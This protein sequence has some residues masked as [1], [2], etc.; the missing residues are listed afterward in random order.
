MRKMQKGG[1][2][3]ACGIESDDGP[4][5]GNVA[6]VLDFGVPGIAPMEPNMME[7]VRC[8]RCET[9]HRLQT[10]YAE[11]PTEAQRMHGGRT[12]TGAIKLYELNGWL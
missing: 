4:Y 8:D 7:P 3:A 5:W 6:K 11:S 12:L 9:M 10:D 2:C 1:L